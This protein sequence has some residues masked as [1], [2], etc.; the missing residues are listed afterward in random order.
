M[1]TCGLERSNFSFDIF[2]SPLVQKKRHRP[3][4]PVPLLPLLCN[5]LDFGNHLF[6]NVLRRLIVA[7][8][9]HGRSGP[10]LS[11]RTQVRRVT[12]HLRKRH[13]RGDHLR[14]A[15]SGFGLL[16]LSTPAHQVAIDS[17]HVLIRCNHLDTHDGLQQ[18]RLGLSHCILE[19]E[20]TGDVERAL[21][22][23]D[24]VIITKHE[25][26]LDVYQLVTGEEATPHRV[27]NAVLNRLDVLLRNRATRDLV[28]K[29]ETLTG[30]GFDLDLDVAE[31]TTT[32]SLFLVDFL[33]GRRLRDRFAIGHLRLADI[34]LD[35]KLALH[36]I[37]DDLEV[38]LTHAGDDRLAGFG[39]G[40]NV[41][42][43]IFLRETIQRHAEFVLILTRLRL[44]RDA[45]HG[46]R[47]LHLLENDRLRFV[48]NRVAGSDLLHATDGD[49]LACARVLDVFTLVRVHPHQTADAFLT[50]LDWVVRVR[51]SFDGATVNAN[52]RQLAEVL[53]SHD[54]ED[55]TR[56]RR[57]RIRGTSFRLIVFRIVSL[58][59]R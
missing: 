14:A 56:K 33:A 11:C 52:E 18:Y 20:R 54:L 49:N 19:R 22:R 32:A 41:E 31:L 21:I 26:H 2:L 24:F 30:S 45:N 55:K 16:N 5:S 57:R 25:P 8:E 17:T 46:R 37:D 7:L 34:R 42:R 15:G 9:V 48:A 29:H 6:R 35:A 1:F 4:Q 36:A 47:E 40:G 51:T 13:E 27:A 39:I 50:T 23:V 38:Q 53:V 3:Y 43:R 10:A 28:L 59:R 58:D 44:D 12:K